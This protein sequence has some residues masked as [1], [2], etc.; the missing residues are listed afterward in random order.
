[1]NVF[2]KCAGQL[3]G[4]IG[5]VCAYIT[6]CSVIESCISFFFLI[7]IRFSKTF[8]LIMLISFIYF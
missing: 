2:S 1:M 6:F 7:N 3:L 8:T 5:G 4:V